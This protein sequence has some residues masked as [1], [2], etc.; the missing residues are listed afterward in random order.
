IDAVSHELDSE[1]RMSCPRCAIELK[2]K[3]MIGHLWDKHRLVLDG[4]RVR[5]P[6][7]VIEDWVVDYGLEKDPQVLQRCRELAARVDPQNGPAR[8]QRLLYQRGIR[9][10]EL[11]QEMRATVKSRKV[12]LCPHC[13]V[14]MPIEP[15]AEIE[16]LTLKKSRLEGFGYVVEVSERGLVPTLVLESPDAIIFRAREP[17]R[18]LTRLGGILV[19]VLP[20]MVGLF[21]G[22]SWFTAHELP[23]GLLATVAVGVGLLWAGFLYLAWPD[24]SAI[25]ERLLKAAWNQ[26][27]PSILR[28]KKKGRKAWSFLHSLLEYSE[29]LAEIKVSADLLLDCC[30][31]ASDAAKTDPC[32]ALCLAAFSQRYLAE[33][34]EAGEDYDH[35][36]TTLAGECFKGKLP[37]SFLS[38]L[39]ENF[40]G[41]ERSHWKKIDLNRVPMLIAH[42]AFLADV[43]LEDWLSLGRAFPILHAVLNLESRSHWQRFFALWH[44]RHRKPWE[45]VAPAMV[46][47]DLAAAPAEHEELLAHY[48]DVLL[49]VPTANLVIGTRGIWIEGVC[50]TSYRPGTTIAT[51]RG[52]SAYELQIGELRIRCAENPRAYLDDIKRWLRWYF[53]EFLP[54]VPTG[55]RP[56]AESRHRMWQLDKTAC[57][58]CAR[59]LVPCPADLGVPLK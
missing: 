31:K 8:L 59:P 11:L 54:T 13:C 3:D 17:G 23:P 39:L 42:Q 5:E 12:T 35:F 24:P 32:A 40:H 9:D 37:L 25:R 56:L 18:G 26:L 6:W 7:R 53:Q 27:V 33:L 2:K 49:Y 16:P 28:D 20:V 50:V 52:T 58:D 48:P 45:D 30:E 44:Q 14:S 19:L 21:V 22:L 47:L 1:I 10:P 29:G 15:R 46:M 38:D 4:E 55:Q 51:D 43:N 36:L 34:R 57:P 41:A